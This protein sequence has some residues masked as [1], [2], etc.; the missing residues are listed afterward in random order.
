MTRHYDIVGPFRLLRVG[1]Q[2]YRWIHSRRASRWNRARHHGDHENRRARDRECPRV[3][4]LHPHEPR[5]EQRPE[6]PCAGKTRDEPHEDGPHSPRDERPRHSR[7]HRTQRNAQADV[8][9][10]TAHEERDQA[11]E[12]DRTEQQREPSSH[13]Q[14]ILPQPDLR[15]TGIDRPCRRTGGPART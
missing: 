6:D 14:H 12:A 4:R 3:V 11:I 2:R 10:P 5:V 1:S 13:D 7:R 15:T 9:S 8:T